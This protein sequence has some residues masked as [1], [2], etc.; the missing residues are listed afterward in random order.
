MQKVILG[1]LRKGRGGMCREAADND[2]LG[3]GIQILE[4]RHE[5]YDA[6]RSGIFTFMDPALLSMD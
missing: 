4:A 3:I 2:Y 5:L 1:S 6:R